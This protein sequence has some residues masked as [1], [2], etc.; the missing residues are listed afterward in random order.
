MSLVKDYEGEHIEEFP[1]FINYFGY[2][3]CV[4]NCIFG[5]WIDYKTYSEALEPKKWVSV[6]EPPGNENRDF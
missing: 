6:A 3:F 4:G 1:R 5:P 2:M